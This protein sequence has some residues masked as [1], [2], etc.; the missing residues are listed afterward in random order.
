MTKLGQSIMDF[1][2]GAFP[3]VAEFVLARLAALV[4]EPVTAEATEATA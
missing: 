1:C 4:P 3:A 2:D